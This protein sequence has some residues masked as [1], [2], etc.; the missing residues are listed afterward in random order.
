VLIDTSKLRLPSALFICPII[1]S[2]FIVYTPP[3]NS[4]ILSIQ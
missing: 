1:I 3:Y 2:L 4:T